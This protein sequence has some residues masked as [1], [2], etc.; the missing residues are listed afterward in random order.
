MNT[1]LEIL[2]KFLY[3]TA[4]DQL[5]IGHRNSEWTGIG[6]ILEEDIAF[7][8]IAQDK[9]G[10]AYSIY[11]ILHEQLNQGIP[12]IIGFTRNEN[13]FW[14]CQL[15]E[16]PIGE[17]DFS[18]VRHFLFDNAEFI[19]FNELSNCTY[20]P[21]AKLSNKI[22]GEIKYHVFHADSWMSQLANGTEESKNR[23]QIAINTLLPIAF[24]I[25]EPIENESELQTNF[26][27]TS[28]LELQ[29]KWFALISEKLNSWGYSLPIN[30][31]LTQHLGGRNGKHT[32]FLQ[33]L[34][35]EM[36]EVFRLDPE[37]KW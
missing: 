10:H 37:A 16:H 11:S 35:V 32:P 29:T 14:S 25:F 27:I 6:P 26:S 7:S 30:F 5:I 19:R 22:K 36:T 8:S 4:D 33:P 23:I 12:D 2:T 13:E 24:S 31:D 1:T 9:I 20:E 28:E 21:L 34:I 3:K 17:Y 15:V 18:L